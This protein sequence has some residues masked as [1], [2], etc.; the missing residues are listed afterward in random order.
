MLST[1]TM[2]LSTSIPAPSASPPSVTMFRLWSPNRIRNRAA[3]IDTGTAA[4]TTSVAPADRRKIASTRTASSTPTPA[5]DWSSA[6]A[7]TTSAA[8]S[9]TSVSSTLGRSSARPTSASLTVVD[10]STVFDPASLNTARPTPSTP[11]TRTRW[12]ISLSTISTRPRS[13]TRT[14]WREPSVPER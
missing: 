5:A 10:T 1:T 4:A 7:S 12:S 14:A 2:A 9:V 8:S 3:K 11:F 6:R 13:D